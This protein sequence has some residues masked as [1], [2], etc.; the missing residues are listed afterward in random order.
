MEIM[1]K[2]AY[3]KGL[4]EG[5]EIDTGKKEGKILAAII[6]VLEEL[7]LEAILMADPDF[8]FVV[9]QS[10]DPQAAKDVLEKTLFSNPAWKTLTAV[11]EGRYHVMD[12]SLYN[13]KPNARWGEAYEKLAEILYGEK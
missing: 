1:E 13:L 10:A 8:I 6:D 12:S 7:S 5:M 9:E 4:V 3:L 11:R 2:V